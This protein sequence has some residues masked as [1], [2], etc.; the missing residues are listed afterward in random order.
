MTRPRQFRRIVAIFGL[1]ALLP[2][3]YMLTMGDITTTD[4]AVRAVAT[5]ALVLLVDRMIGMGWRSSQRYLIR[6]QAAE[7]AAATRQD[8]G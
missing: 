2:T 1:V 4:A 3:A 7:R 6:R 5:F 8:Q